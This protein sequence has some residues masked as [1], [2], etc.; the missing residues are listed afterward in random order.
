MNWGSL[1]RGGGFL[2]DRNRSS[3][4]AWGSHDYHYGARVK[5][6]RKTKKQCQVETV[7]NTAD[8]HQQK[9]TE[10]TASGAGLAL[11]TQISNLLRILDL[12]LS[13]GLSSTQ[14]CKLLISVDSRLLLRE[15]HK[16]PGAE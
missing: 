4:S 9:E 8:L 1:K 3:R 12:F 15:Q 11:F 6:S 2:I 7:L 13:V 5:N 14:E 10:G 16:H